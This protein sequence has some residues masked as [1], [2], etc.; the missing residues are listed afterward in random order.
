V[1][2]RWQFHKFGGSSLADATC[3]KRVAGIVLAMP[4]RRV[5]VVVSAMGGMTDALL[6][7]AALAEQADPSYEA[8]LHAIGDRYAKTARDLV[9][10]ERLVGVLDAWGRDA[11][12]IRDVLKA[13]S[14]VKSAPQRSRD[15]VAGYGEIWSARLLAAYLGQEA[16]RRGGTW[17]DA[18]QV[19][20]IRAT[21]LGPSVLWQASQARFDGNVAAD[22][23]GIA[24]FTGFIA[25]DEEGLQTTL[26]RNGSDFS[27]AI[28]AAL[29]KAEELTIWTDVDGVMSADPNRVPEAR[30]IH[31]LTYN[32]A[33]DISAR[34]CCTRKHWGPR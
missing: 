27:A 19:I 10:G 31:H 28:F 20:T 14:L 12:D 13:I 6:R 1:Q 5:G 21:E 25:S 11:D 2:D 34:R 3:F 23:H 15:V 9:V 17:V 8:E 32:E 7:L 30:V 33:M 26:G 18:R 16:P 24:V 4:G 29:A 22:F